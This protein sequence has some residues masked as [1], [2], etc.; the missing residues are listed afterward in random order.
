MEVDI[1][2]FMGIVCRGFLGSARR[3]RRGVVMQIHCCRILSFC[4]FLRPTWGLGILL[5]TSLAEGQRPACSS[6]RRLSLSAITEYDTVRQLME[7]A[8]V[9][10]AA[11]AA[12]PVSKQHRSNPSTSLQLIITEIHLYVEPRQ[13]A[14]AI[15]GRARRSPRASLRPT[16]VAT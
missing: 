14:E 1:I 3:A 16:H 5:P 8:I 7:E 12:R 13:R 6:W 2:S 15:A 9:N 10:F 4:C 11:P